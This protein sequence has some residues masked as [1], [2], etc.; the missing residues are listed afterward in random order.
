M[1]GV[2]EMKVLVTGGAGFIGS[3]IVDQVL[4]GG[5]HVV[6]IDNMSSGKETN[7]HPEAAF[8]RLDMENPQVKDI[9]AQEKPDIVIHQAA[10]TVVQTSVKEPVYDAHMNILGT[11][12]LLEAARLHGVKKF[13]YASSA[14][15]Y[16]DPNYVPIDEK[17]AVEPSSG[18]GISK[19][20]PE[21]YLRVYQHMYGLDYT[22][23]RYANVYGIRQDPHG[24][25]GVVSIFIDK[26]IGQQPFI[27]FGDGEQT[28][29]YIYV[30]DV[31]RANVAALE[32]GGGEIFNIG[33]GV[34]TTLNELV[35]K[36]QQISGHSEQT[37]YEPERLGD[38]KH[39]YFTVEKA[40]R[41]LHWSPTVSLAEGLEKTYQFY[42]GKHS[43]KIL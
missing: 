23:L 35:T 19:Y 17:H 1:G 36:L 3:H 13:I 14:A 34:H 30:E 31:A 38:I 10:Q 33:T 32:D 29:D 18:Y 6:I 24:E 42:S 43:T 2:R 11:I 12:N 27:I 4:A 9:F 22:I 28:R 16:G 37:I 20:T 7:L 41:V 8:Y 39:S 21:Q 26:A 15:V 5:H 25:G 40:T